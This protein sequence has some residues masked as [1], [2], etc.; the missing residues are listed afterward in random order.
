MSAREDVLIDVL[1]HLV[2]AVSLLE[3]GGK[4]AAG[5]DKMYLQMLKDYNASIERGRAFIRSERSAASS[6][7]G[8]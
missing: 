4:K 8:G 1:A 2:A 6:A 3:R 7:A 5:S